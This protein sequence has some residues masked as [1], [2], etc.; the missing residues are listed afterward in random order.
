MPYPIPYDTW[1]P[2]IWKRRGPIQLYGLFKIENGQYLGFTE[3]SFSMGWSTNKVRVWAKKDKNVEH[4]LQSY[5]EKYK[6]TP[7]FVLRLTRSNSPIICDFKTRH[8][9]YSAKT[10]KKYD[11]RNV[12]F[13]MNPSWK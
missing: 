3:N 7:F 11:G 1:P 13:A 5:I 9:Q 2:D 8:D 10:L 4:Y 12:G 6:D